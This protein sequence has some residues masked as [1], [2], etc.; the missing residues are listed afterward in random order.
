MLKYEYQISWKSVQWEPSCF[1]RTD[2]HTDR[3]KD[4]QACSFTLFMS[5][6]S[7]KN[8]IGQ[9]SI[10]TSH[11]QCSM[12][13]LWSSLLITSKKLATGLQLMPVKSHPHLCTTVLL[14]YP[15]PW[16]SLTYS[17]EVSTCPVWLP[18]RHNTHALRSHCVPW[19]Q[20]RCNACG[21]A[22]ACQLLW[23]CLI[24]QQTALIQP[25]CL[26]QLAV[27]FVKTKH[28]VLKPSSELNP[29]RVSCNDSV[30]ILATACFTKYINPLKPSDYYIYHHV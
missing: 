13:R 18:L 28:T 17:W 27:N 29:Y 30:L 12:C 20:S 26:G 1:M 22:Q 5:Y 7:K 2:R 6:H 21:C 25:S 24:A 9:L 3:R 4:R 11:T 23:W 16:H 19:A 15:P 10:Q 8:K 14:S